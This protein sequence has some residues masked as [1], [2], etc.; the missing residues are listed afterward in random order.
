MKMQIS[1]A[2]SLTTIVSRTF[3]SGSLRGKLN[4][5]NLHESLKL[6]PISV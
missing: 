1:C 2:S 4:R 3:D 5:S 6:T